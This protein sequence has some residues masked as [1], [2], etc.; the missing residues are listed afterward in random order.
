LV[1]AAASL[2]DVV[3]ELGGEYERRSGTRVDFNFAGSNILAQQIAAAAQADV[4][5]SAD[6][7]WIDFLADKGRIIP[8]SRQIFLQNKLVVIA[9]VDSEIRIEQAAD[10]ATCKYKYLV[11][12]DPEAVPAGRYTKSWLENRP[13]A[14]SSLW[15]AVAPRVAP[16]LDV[17]AA[18]ALVESDPL[19]VGVVYAS[20]QLTS[21]R[22]RVLFEPAKDQQPRISYGA[23]LIAMDHPSAKAAH[24]FEFLV[25][26]ESQQTYRLHGFGVP[27]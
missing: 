13:Y 9:R 20:D 11:I 2:R 22:T 10:L 14:G 15:Q 27:E 19:L 8:G 25:G 5:L 12:A 16:A 3:T 4:F 24:F 21:K 17:R 23:A 6:Q 1:A 26:A 18:L 7:R